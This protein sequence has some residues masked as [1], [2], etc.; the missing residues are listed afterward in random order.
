[1]QPIGETVDSWKWKYPVVEMKTAAMP[2]TR[3]TPT[4]GAGGIK[5]A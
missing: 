2:S 5:A 4:G 3:D 1:M